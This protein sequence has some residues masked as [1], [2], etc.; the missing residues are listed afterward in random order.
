MIQK[1]VLRAGRFA[2][3]QDKKVPSVEEM[4]LELSWST[5]QDWGNTAKLSMLQKIVTGTVEV[6]CDD[7][8]YLPA[9]SP[10]AQK[11]TN[12]RNHTWNRIREPQLLSKDHQG[13][14]QHGSV[15]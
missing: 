15:T 11:K 9:R 3:N 5:R 12:E 7:L 10:R 8:Q 13:L 6:A 2:L 4:L 1:V 14:E